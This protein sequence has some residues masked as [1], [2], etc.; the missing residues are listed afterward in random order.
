V[1][2]GPVGAPPVLGRPSPAAAQPAPLRSMARSGEAHFRAEGGDSGQ[3]AL[4]AATVAGVRHRLA[5]RGGEDSYAWAHGSGWLVV[6]VADGVGSTERA[7]E[8]AT[9]AVNTAVH[10]GAA[11]VGS[12]ADPEGDDGDGNGPYPLPLSD[13][14]SAALHAAAAALSAGGGPGATTLV[15]A[16]LDASGRWGA[17]RVGDSTALVLGPSGW[18]DVFAAGAATA[19]EG[20]VTL[21]AALPADAVAEETASGSLSG[22]EALVLLTD[23]VADPL[24]DGPET[25]APALAASLR[26]PPTPLELATLA[27]FSRQG[28]HDDRTVLGVWRLSGAPG[29]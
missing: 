13:V 15:V 2:A 11:L 20:Q 24:R 23:G 1:A 26:H 21:T 17:A 27:D 22:G 28:C 25:V 14:A 18:A 7:G 12:V 16:A 5:G 19:D 9:E 29:E 3:L 6:A 8:A 10:A 4:R